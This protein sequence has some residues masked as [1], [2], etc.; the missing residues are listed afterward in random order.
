V[1]QS[2]EKDLDRPALRRTG[3]SEIVELDSKGRAQ[4]DTDKRFRKTGRGKRHKN[5][6]PR[7]ITVAPGGPVS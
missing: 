2:R 5:G 1:H 4:K 3:V 6:L 7:M